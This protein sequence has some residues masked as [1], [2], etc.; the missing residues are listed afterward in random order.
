MYIVLYNDSL[1]AGKRCVL[2]LA[3]G[4]SPSQIYRLLAKEHKE[5]GLSFKHVITFNL[6]EYYPMDPNA[7]QSYHRFMWESLFDHIDIQKANVHIPEGA[8]ESEDDIAR[9]NICECQSE[10]CLCRATE[11]T[12][13]F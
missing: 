5:K 9:S 7:L 4:S 6:D 13:W 12:A 8:L 1:S 11:I 2:G 3:T 10:D